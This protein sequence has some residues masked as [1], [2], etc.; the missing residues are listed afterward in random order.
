[1]TER[2][3][4]RPRSRRGALLVAALLVVSTPVAGCNLQPTQYGFDIWNYSSNRYVVRLTFQDGTA[5]VVAMPPRN[6]VFQHSVPDPQQAVFYDQ[7]CSSQLATL[8]LSGSWAY[9]LIDASGAISVSASPLG[10]GGV[11]TDADPSYASPEPVLSS[12]PST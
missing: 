8:K 2:S 3:S 5:R 11:H 9:V 7:T 4:R 10:S 12:C 6:I 1:M